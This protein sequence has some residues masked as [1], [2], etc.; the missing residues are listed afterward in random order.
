M[1]QL[2]FLEQCN[3]TTL[4]YLLFRTELVTYLE[5]Y[6]IFQILFGKILCLEIWKNVVFRKLVADCTK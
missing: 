3:L 5:T 2:D 6:G 4:N 1:S